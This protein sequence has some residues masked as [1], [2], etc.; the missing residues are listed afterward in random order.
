MDF[1]ESVNLSYDELKNQVRLLQ[2]ALRSRELEI[3]ELRSQLDKFQ[4]VFAFSPTTNLLSP[5][6][7][8][9]VSLKKRTRT[10]LIGI[11]AEPAPGDSTSAGS[12]VQE[13]IRT[14]PKNE[15]TKKFLEQAI[16]SNEFMKRLDS[17]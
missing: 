15:T 13:P 8:P 1:D 3:V 6:P 14:F 7:A 9:V 2:E 17:E 5:V 4:A 12:L 11:S 10:R 16:Q